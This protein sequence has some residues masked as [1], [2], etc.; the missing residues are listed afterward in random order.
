MKLKYD[1]LLSKFAF[2]SNM[3]H[4]TALPRATPTN[5][6]Y[7]LYLAG[8]LCDQVR[9][10]S[11]TPGSLAVDTTLLLSGTSALKIST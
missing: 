4:Y 8:A 1:E 3:W 7:G 6:M 5:G 11:F 9:R 2:N 10:C